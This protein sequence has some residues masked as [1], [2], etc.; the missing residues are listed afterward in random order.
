M[1]VICMIRIE[2]RKKEDS[3]LQHQVLVVK[4]SWYRGNV[5]NQGGF[6]FVKMILY[7]SLVT[8]IVLYPTLARVLLDSSRQQHQ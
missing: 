4:R 6:L 2:N 8:Q 7:Q 5:N 1:C 3:N